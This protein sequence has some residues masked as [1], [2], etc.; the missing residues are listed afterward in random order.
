MLIGGY[1]GPWLDPRAAAIITLDP[2]SLAAH[3]AGFGCGVIAVLDGD[4]C[5]VAELARVAHWYAQASARQCG[6]CT[7]GLR[8]LATATTAIAAGDPDPK[9]TADI[10]RWTDM[11]KGRGGCRLPDGAAAFLQSGTEVFADEIS[12]H[13]TGRCTR[14]D[15]GLLPTPDPDPWL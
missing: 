2:S 9:A 7:W 11:I 4:T 10:R 8:D 6:A 15:R 13:Q 12:L 1:F 14:S 5:A 3:E